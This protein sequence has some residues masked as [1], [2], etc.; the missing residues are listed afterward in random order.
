MRYSADWR[1]DAV[2][3]DV[4]E[5]AT[6]AEF[7]LWLNDQNV[8]FHLCGTTSTDYIVIPLCSLANGLAHD[9]WT[10]FGGRDADISLTRYRNGYVFPDI[11]LAFDG[12]AFEMSAHQRIYRNPDLR[13]WAGQAEVLARAQAEDHLSSLIADV[14]DRLESRGVPNTGLASRW[15][16]VQAS[17]DDP[18]EAEFCEAAGALGLDPYSIDG[19][20]AHAIEEASHRFSGEPL[21]E[22]LAGAR[23]TDQRKLVDWIDGVERRPLEASHVAGLRAAA[24]EARKLAPAKDNEKSWALGYRRARALRRAL[25]LPDGRR[26][27]SFEVLA[28]HLGA[29]ESFELA[30]SV[31]GIR[32]L[33]NDQRGEVCLHMRG[34][35]RDVEA[36]AGHLFTFA[37]G[38]GDVACFPTPQRSPV[39]DLHSAYR[40]AA[41]RAF[42]AEFLA[43]LNEL[44]DMMAGGRDTVSIAEEFAVSTTVVERQIENEKRIEAACA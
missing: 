20:R 18:E 4:E 22:F 38:V 44:K 2:N 25:G 41:G 17:R 29:S 16:R 5:R 36:V 32:L 1:E 11:R 19:E 3:V 37:R 23:L 24:E 39:N 31:D 8:C 42:A 33:R 21:T 13:F 30:P 35:G 15:A 9:W 26:F 6:L 28:R 7:R 34:H 43:P 27:G 12:A 14:L 40:Q 10:I